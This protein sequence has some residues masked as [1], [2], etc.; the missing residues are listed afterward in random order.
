M[1]NT[2]FFL[3]LIVISFISCQQKTN[4]FTE[5]IRFS[6][7]EKAF[8]KQNGLMINCLSDIDTSTT[9]GLVAILSY[10]ISDCQSCVERGYQILE[11]IQSNQPE[12]DVAAIVNDPNAESK[13][14]VYQYAGKIFNDS[15]NKLIKELSY[16]FTPHIILMRDGILIKGYYFDSMIEHDDDVEYFKNFLRTL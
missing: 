6:K 7:A 1:R 8:Q 11:H 10:T 5:N 12:F 16:I 15:E 9:K 3:A 13:R 4:K 14:T 2:I